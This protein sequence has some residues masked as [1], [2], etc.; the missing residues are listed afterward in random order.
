[1]PIQVFISVSICVHLW[2]KSFSI[3]S[4]RP[5]QPLTHPLS[6]VASRA[7]GYSRGVKSAAK[8]CLV[9]VTA[10]DLKT[11]RALARAALR[12]KLIACANLAPRIESHYWWQGRIESGA[13]V[14]MLMKTSRA[15]LV[16]LEKLILEKHPYD[17]PEFLVL[18][19]QKGSGKFLDWLGVNLNRL[20]R[21]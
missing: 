9:L 19:L 13:E 21:K 8:F 20:R 11:A 16:A 14:L 1:M 17:T 3:A 7:G 4:F 18:P 12:D 5:R 2:L 6:L 15:R 10:P